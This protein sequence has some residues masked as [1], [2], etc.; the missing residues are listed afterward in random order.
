MGDMQE[1]LTLVFMRQ[2]CYLQD[3]FENK[4]LLDQGTSLHILPEI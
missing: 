2:R 4:Q 1:Q 3:K